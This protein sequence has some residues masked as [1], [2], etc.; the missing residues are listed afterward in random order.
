MNKKD[1]YYKIYRK[2]KENGTFS[3]VD[4]IFKM[5]Y[6]ND[7]FGFDI[8]YR[9]LFKYCDDFTFFILKDMNSL[10]KGKYNCVNKYY[11]RIYK[12]FNNE[13]N[14]F[15]RCQKFIKDMFNRNDYKYFITFT[16]DN[17]HLLKYVNDIALFKRVVKRYLNSFIDFNYYV[18]NID[19]GSFN[20][21]LHIHCL[22]SC[23]YDRLDF[24]FLQNHYKLGNLDIVRCYNND[25]SKLSRYIL[26]FVFHAFKNTTL[27]KCVY[28]RS[29]K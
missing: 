26:K 23:D 25:A 13:K 22:M 24:K 20:G 17:K 7:E 29:R 21:R 11:E 3:F 18:F 1:Y 19:Y 28:G 8:D 27:C 10:I 12:E 16:L 6:L 2:Y 14:R 5:K 15:F 9:P 4:K